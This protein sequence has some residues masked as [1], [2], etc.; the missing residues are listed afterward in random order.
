MNHRLRSRLDI[1]HPEISRKVKDKQKS[2]PNKLV[3]QSSENDDVFVR[4]FSRTPRWIPRTILKAAG[5]LM[6]RHIDH[7]RNRESS[8]H[9]PQSLSSPVDF[10]LP[11]K[12]S[13]EDTTKPYH[14]DP[15][16]ADCHHR[17]HASL[18]E[19]ADPQIDTMVL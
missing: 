6:S 9:I 5:P 4:N 11:T 19:I 7:L 14:A 3:R 17:H 1:L 10:D 12:S 2:E 8:S 15:P 13:Q 18:S 16:I